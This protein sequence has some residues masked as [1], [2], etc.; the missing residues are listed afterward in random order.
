MKIPLAFITIL[1]TAIIS[2]EGWQLARIESLSREIGIVHA[3]LNQ[4]LHDSGETV[5]R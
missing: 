4:H 3:L 1:L 2:L 5:G